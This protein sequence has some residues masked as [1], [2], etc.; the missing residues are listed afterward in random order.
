MEDLLVARRP[1]PAAFDTLYRRERIL[2]YAYWLERGAKPTFN[3]IGTWIPD[4]MRAELAMWRSMRAK[5]FDDM[6]VIN[7]VTGDLELRF[8]FRLADV[9]ALV[10]D[11]ELARR[12]LPVWNIAAECLVPQKLGDYQIV[13]MSSYAQQ[14]EGQSYAYQHTVTT[15]PLTLYI[16]DCGVAQVA[17]GISDPRFQEHL[18]NCINDVELHATSHGRTGRR[19]IEPQAE[20]ICSPA[21]TEIVFA[22]TSWEFVAADGQRG[23]EAL[24][25]TGFRD[26][27]LKVRLTCPT[28]FFDTGPGQAALD[29]MNLDLADFVAEFGTPKPSD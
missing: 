23:F 18:W 4:E 11:P 22:S 19:L 21:G 20:V 2:R 17:P 29:A 1:Y 28:A 25:L 7:A 16:Y 5:D 9:R 15:A 14:Y 26:M 8:G 6:D 12:N 13:G 10:A 24:S 3:F 27:F